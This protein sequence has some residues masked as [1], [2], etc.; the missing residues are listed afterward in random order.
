MAPQVEKIGASVTTQLLVAGRSPIFSVP[1]PS[2]AFSL[3]IEATESDS[4]P[5]LQLL[6]AWDLPAVDQL[7]RELNPV[8]TGSLEG[9]VFAPQ[10]TT[11]NG[12]YTSLRLDLAKSTND[13]S[14]ILDLIANY[15]S[16]G[17][18]DESRSEACKKRENDSASIGAECALENAK[19]KARENLDEKAARKLLH[20]AMLIN[21]KRELYDGL[22]RFVRFLLQTASCIPQR[23]AAEF[24]A[25][26]PPPYQATLFACLADYDV[27]LEEDSLIEAIKSALWSDNR[28][29]A[30]MAA[31]ALYS[32][33]ERA[34]G[35]LAAAMPE[36]P[37]TRRTALAS[38]LSIVPET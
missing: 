25:N 26:A 16:S 6:R 36:L 3:N 9:A 7:Y 4:P 24:V 20:A 27:R 38:L 30:H 37:D 35:A 13:L 22:Q 21:S 2:S 29:V 10:L 5:N 8:S 31:L 17:R 11:K 34:N 19:S 12:G 15:Q 33:G 14:T 1:H 28:Q 32:G 18:T 23:I